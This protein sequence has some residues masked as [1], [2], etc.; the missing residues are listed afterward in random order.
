MESMVESMAEGIIMLDE[1]GQIAVLNPVARQILGWGR[2]EEISSW[3]FHEKMRLVNLDKSLQECLDKKYLVSKEIIIPKEESQII[4]CDIVPVR[5]MQNNIIGTAIIL[6]DIT[7]EKEVDKM[8]TEFVSTVSHELRTPLATMKEF[9]SIISDEIPGKLTKDQREYIDI[10]KGNIDRL[11]R[12]INNL[13][14]I[15][16]IEAGKI[17]VKKTHIAIN[18]LVSEMLPTL[19]PQLDGKHIEFK[20]SIPESTMN[21]YADPDKIIQIFTNLIGNAIK[22]TPE[23]GQIT[24]EIKDMEKEIGCSV[25]DTGKGIAGEDMPKL[26]TKFQQFDRVPGAGA[27]GTG[28]GLAI[29]K[30]LV[31]MHGGRIWAESKLGKGSKFT[32]T[33]PKYTAEA[34]FTVHVNNGIKEALDKNTKMSLVIVALAN[35]DKLK[36]ELSHENLQTILKDMEG[37][38]KNSLRH[39]REDVVVRDSGEI[40]VILTGCDKDNS[41][42]IEGRLNQALE[43]YLTRQ[44]LTDKIMLRF[45]RAT[46][47]D[48]AKS[49][50][51]LIEKAKKL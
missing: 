19:K 36:Q 5:D 20:T 45:G 18:N 29:T 7:R 43:D 1:R 27:K 47:P 14:D 23:K 48:E 32:F 39:G 2:K 46:Y 37:I 6:R 9:T 40:I 4:R 33:L 12:L 44:K 41:L 50:E 3:T 51:A 35:F 49:D 8:K 42:K 17:E 11:A 16:K 13:L 30:E 22:F 26:F 15:S 31:R 25:A 38:L 28:L 24:L 21:V 10:I 34:L